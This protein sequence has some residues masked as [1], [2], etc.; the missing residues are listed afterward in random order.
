MVKHPKPL[1]EI[2][3]TGRYLPERIL[4]NAELEKM[5]DT[6]DEWIRERT[7]I[8]ERRIA[9]EGESA[10]DMG[11]EAARRAMEKAGVEPGEIDVIVLSTATPDRWLPSTAC[12]MQALLGAK[13]A[14]AFDV[15]AACTGWLYALSTAEGFLAAGRGDVALVVGTER[16]SSIIDW[17]DR[18]TCVLFGDAAGAAVLRRSNGERGIISTHHKSDGNLG[19][20]LYRPA[21]GNAIPF[22]Q[23]VLASGDHLLRMS[24]REV[25]KN[26]VRSMADAAET[27]LQQGGFT[28]DDIDLLIPHQA[29][30]RI[31]Q[32]TAKYAGLPMETLYVNVDR[33]GN[34]S[35]AAIPVA[36]DEVLEKGL[37][38]PGS[39]ILTCAFGSGFTWSGMTIRL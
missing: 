11:A 5:V 30:I 7:G 6:S 12:D 20:L 1:V 15:V 8:R 28:G 19:N 21:G 4:T 39:L 16:M 23:E 2:A 25:F 26:A 18:G 10:A 37:A 24:G 14:V 38:G 9:A 29:N 22:S 13:N 27:A 36:L 33:Y 31:I 35:S 17:E 3:G 34:T 32:A